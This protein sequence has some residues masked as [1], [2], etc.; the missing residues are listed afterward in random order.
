MDEIYKK[1]RDRRSRRRWQ[2]FQRKL[3]KMSCGGRKPFILDYR[4]KKEGRSLAILPDSC[5]SFPFTESHFFSSVGGLRRR[6]RS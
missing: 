1:E 4:R 3:K 6:M 2:F 5:P